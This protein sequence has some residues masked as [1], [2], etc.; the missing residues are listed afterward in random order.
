M[1]LG[2]L[3][4]ALWHHC[5]SELRPEIAWILVSIDRWKY[6]VIFSTT[7]AVSKMVRLVTMEKKLLSDW[8][9]DLLGLRKTFQ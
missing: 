9:L 4:D 6:I 3:N 1:S 2:P 8:L 5:R 7:W